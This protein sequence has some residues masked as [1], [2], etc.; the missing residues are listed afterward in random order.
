[1]NCDRS[2]RTA[3]PRVVMIALVC[4]ACLG[5]G[6][7]TIGPEAYQ[8]TKALYSLANRRAAERIDAV[9]T[10]IK[11]ATADEKLSK[12]ESQLLLAICQ[13]CRDGDWTEAQRE[14]RQLMEDQVER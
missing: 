5:C 1:M 6:Q 14:A 10:Q 2:C 12:R 4:L 13:R 7:E 11:A 3:T 9:E 8:Y